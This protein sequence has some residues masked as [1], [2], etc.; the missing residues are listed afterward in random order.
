MAE[1]V[2][3][4][5]SINSLCVVPPNTDRLLGVGAPEGYHAIIG[6][7]IAASV[8][9]D[10]KSN[11][12]TALRMLAEC[13]KTLNRSMKLPLSDQ[14]V[15]CFVSFMANRNVK[16][17]TI[18]NY[19][20]GIRLALLSSGYECDN[21]RTPVVK[22]VLKGIHNLRRDPQVEVK[23]KTRRAMTIA[24]LRLLGHALSKSKLSDYLKSAVW[25]VALLA[26]W[27]ALRIGEVLCPL[28]G[29]FDKKSTLLVS[30]ISISSEFIRVWI[31]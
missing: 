22:Q 26:F 10:T 8:A 23:K 24:H 28:S 14:D 31:R 5:K 6:E 7:A 29:A 13:Q 25:A 21:L 4:V 16:D 19:L 12:N 30:D 9:A 15:L 1:E 18:S 17:T 2:L 11:Y 3:K 27:G 20:S